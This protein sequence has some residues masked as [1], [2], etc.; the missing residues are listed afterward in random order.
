MWFTGKDK[1]VKTA[2]E[3][4]EDI[5]SVLRRASGKDITAIAKQ[6]LGK[7]VE[8][9]GDSIFIVKERG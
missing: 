7:D 3:V 8:Y 1:K 4:I 5:A 6:I 9:V 2:D